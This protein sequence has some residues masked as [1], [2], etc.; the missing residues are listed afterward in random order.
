MKEKLLDLLA[1]NSLSELGFNLNFSLS[2]HGLGNSASPLILMAGENASGKSVICRLL[3]KLSIEHDLRH[4]EISMGDRNSKGVFSKI[5]EYG[6]YGDEDRES[7]GYLTINRIIKDSK[8]LLES[9]KDFCFVLDEAELGLSE[10]YHQA[11]GQLIAR[12]HADFLASGRCRAFLVCSH[13]RILLKAILASTSPRPSSI[14]LSMEPTDVTLYDWLDS[15]LMHRS[16]D[17]LLSLPERAREK[18]RSINQLRQSKAT[19]Q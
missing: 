1:S 15:P 3:G 8:A 5:R 14:Y 13:S 12:T 9:D 16:I 2:D 11:L 4:V 6:R 19:T 18:R 17:D 10:E 7:T